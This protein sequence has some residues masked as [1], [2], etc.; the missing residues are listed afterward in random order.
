[1]KYT[2][3]HNLPIPLA[4]ALVAG[5][6]YVHSP[7]PHTISVTTLLKPPR[8]IL[9]EKR[10]PASEQTVDV[11]TLFHAHTGTCIHDSLEAAWKSPKLKDILTGLG[12]PSGLVKKIIV[13]PENPAEDDIPVY[14]E[15]RTQKEIMGWTIS[16]Q[17][18]MILEGKLRDLKTTSVNKVNGANE[19]YVLQLSIYR[20][21]NQDKATEDVGSILF[22]LKDWSQFKAY[23]D[24]AYP[25]FPV[26]EKEYRLHSLS[27][28]ENYIRKKL[29]ALQ[30]YHDTPEPELP[31]CTPED[32]WQNPPK[33]KY[34]GKPDAKRASKVF[35]NAGEAQMHL[36]AK[37]KGR[38]EIAP[39]EPTRCKFCSVANRCSQAQGYINAGILRID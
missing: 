18:D 6:K 38:I 1:M 37:G 21:L 34:F 31:L 3:V 32:L 12:L 11:S 22:W 14:T 19:E 9:L 10:I 8:M 35:D 16:G 27:Y 24:P 20:W 7:D 25:R 26:L 13:N 23:N 30:E 15:Q 5:D 33:Y 28:V 36:N 29:T 17:F 2:N 4:V 39:S